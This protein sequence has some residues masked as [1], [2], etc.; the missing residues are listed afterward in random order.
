MNETKR[1]HL[2]VSQCGSLAEFDFEAPLRTAAAMLTRC[3]RGDFT[4][5]IV[6]G[7]AKSAQVGMLESL[8]ASVAA[9]FELEGSLH[10]H[11]HSYV[12]RFTRRELDVAA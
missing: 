6:E 3:A 9:E 1:V 11:P 5:T 2:Q 8:V 10:L 7:V 4:S 12:A